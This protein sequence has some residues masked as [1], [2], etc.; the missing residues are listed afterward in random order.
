ML[1]PTDLR[2]SEDHEWMRVE[3]DVL[4]LGITDYAQSE[5]GDIIFV[6]LP[7]INTI[8]SSKESIGTIEAIKTVADIYS[9]IDG[10]IIDINE[11]INDSPDLINSDPYEKGWLV[12]IKIKV[13]SQLDNMLTKE[14]YMKIVG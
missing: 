8:V 6:E 9:P 13:L 7:D 14:Q 2:Y 5:L 10:E 12:K 4:I 1:I 11:Q 3:K